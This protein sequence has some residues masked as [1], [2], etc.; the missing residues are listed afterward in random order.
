MTQEEAWLKILKFAIYY[1][2]YLILIFE[3]VSSL[4]HPYSRMADWNP[5]A[6][7]FILYLLCVLKGNI[8][9]AMVKNK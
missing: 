2:G 6:L 4:S 9:E 3:F 8:F 7:V 5:L 1:F